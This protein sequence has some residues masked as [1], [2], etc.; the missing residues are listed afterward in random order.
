MYLEA[1]NQAKQYKIDAKNDSELIRKIINAFLMEIPSD[2]IMIE[3]LKEGI[4]RKNAVIEQLQQEI[5]ELKVKKLY[6]KGGKK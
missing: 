4:Q 1:I 5:K 3:Q 6:N 2:R